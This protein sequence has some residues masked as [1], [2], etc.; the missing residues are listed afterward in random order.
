MGKSKKSQAARKRDQEI[1]DQYHKKVTEEALAPLYEEF[2]QW[3]KGERPYYELTEA[4]HK[5][6][7]KNQQI[8]SRFNVTGSEREFLVF[9]AKKEMNLFNEEDLQNEMYIH[10]MDF[11]ER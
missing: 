9:Q 3:K 8:W 6:H 11:F 4:I 5:F 1:L 7:K 10:W 2:L